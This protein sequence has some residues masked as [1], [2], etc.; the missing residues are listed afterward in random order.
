MA[1]YQITLAYDGTHFLGFQRSGRLRTVQGEV[2]AALRALGWRERIILSAGRTDAGVHASGQVI[3]FDLEWNHGAQALGKALN[4]RLPE[5]VAVQ[6]CREAGADFHPR[7]DATRRTYQYRI[8]AQPERNPL[9]ERYAWRV[10]PAPETQRLHLAA[11]RLLGTH[12]FAAFGTP[13]RTGGST[14]RTV[15]H[16]AWQST[17]QGLVFEVS[18]NAFLY[19]MV[20]RLV[21]WQVLTGQGRLSLEQLALAVDAAQALTPGLAPPQGLTLVEVCYEGNR[22]EG[23]QEE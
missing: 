7:Y 8:Y 13:P 10:W 18:A 6:D 3:A 1:H 5:D 9:L 19:H 23:R 14:V 17:P 4:A 11:E 20:R 2:E 21:F 22:A 15:Y 16:A 12:D